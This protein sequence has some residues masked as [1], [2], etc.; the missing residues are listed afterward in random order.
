M[1]PQATGA[2]QSD[3]GLPDNTKRPVWREIV[4]PLLLITA[5]VIAAT[6]A[7]IFN[8]FQQKQQVEII[9]LKAIAE[10]R[11]RQ[12]VD[13]LK[14][15][16]RDTSLLQISPFLG[17]A[18]LQW[19][20]QG[21]IESRN[22]MLN[23]LATFRGDGSFQQAM[24]LD[25]EGEPL[26][27]SNLVDWEQKPLLDPLQRARY[28]AAAES[29]HVTRLGP[30]KDAAG[31]LHLDFVFRLQL[32]DRQPGP[33]VIMHSHDDDYLP[34]SMRDW[35]FPSASGEVLLFRREADHV[36]IISDVRFR[37]EASKTASAAMKLHVPLTAHAV[38]SVQALSDPAKLGQPLE[39]IDYRGEK[40]LGVV[41]AVPGTDWFLLAKRDRRE[42]LA[43]AYENAALTSLVGL[44]TLLVAGFALVSLHHRRRLAIAQGMQDAQGERLRALNL[45][46]S[47]ADSSTDVIY[48]KD[49]EGRYLLFNRE[50]ARVTGKPVDTVLGRDDA[51]LF[52]PE[53]VA[54]IQADDR[55]VIATGQIDSRDQELA[56]IG[57]TRIFQTT[58][59]PLRDG[60]GNVIGIFGSSRDIT[61]R[62]RLEV[63]LAATASF[64]AQAGG[65]SFFQDAVRHL[66]GHFD[67]DYVHVGRL[68][69]ETNQVET[70]AVWRDGQA[71]PNYRYSLAGTPCENVLQ[72]HSVC[73]EANVQAHYPL[74]KELQNLGAQG[75][76]GERMS[77]RDG[78][79]SGLFICISRAPLD[80]GT[81]I[82]SV[83]RI[84]AARAAAELEQQ[85]ALRTL[86]ERELF[87][88]AAVAGA[89]VGLYDWNCLT[90]QVMLAPEWKMQI[91]YADEE[92]PSAFASWQDHLH[93]DDLQRTMDYVMAFVAHPAPVFEIEYRMRHKDGFY[94]WIAARGT[95]TVDDS[96]RCTRLIGGHVDI[97]EHKETEGH[98]RKLA[99]AMEQS[100][101]SVIIVDLD[102]RIEYVN[103]AFLNTTGYT[104]EEVLGQNPRFLQSGKTPHETYDALWDALSHGKSWKG[105]FINRRKDASEYTEF[106][107]ITPLRQSHEAITHYVAVAEDIT[108]RKHLGQELDLHRHH[109]EI[110]VAERTSQLEFALDKAESASRTKAAFLANMSHEIRTPMNAILGMTYLLRRSE[111][112]SRQF[113]Q[114][115]RIEQASRLLL[116]LINDILDL[117]RVESGKLLLESI[118]VAVASIPANVASLLDEQVR[119]KGLQLQVD[120]GTLPTKLSG[121]PTR[122]TQ[123]LLN[124]ASNA[125]KFTRQGIVN[126]RCR[127]LAEDAASA[128]IRFEVED[129]GIGIAPDVVPRLFSA[130]EQA[131]ASTTRR[132][133]GSGLG[134][135][136]TRHLAELMGGEAGA[137]STP[138]VGSTFWFTVR[139]V[140]SN[141]TDSGLTAQAKLNRDAETI[142]ARDYRGT[143][144][145]LV[146]DDPINQEVA[147]GLLESV[148][149]LV[150]L[151][152]NGAVAVRRIASGG[153]FSVI[154]MDMQMP[155]MD[156]VEATRQIRRLENGSHVPILAMTANA[157]AEDRSICLE[158]GMNDFIAKPV[159]PDFLFATLLNWLPVR[160]PRTADA[161][162]PEHTGHDSSAAPSLPAQ[163]APL[164]SPELRKA[165]RLMGG[166][167]RYIQLLRDFATRHGSDIAQLETLLG[168]NR[169]EAARNLIHGLKGAAGS[170]GLIELKTAAAELEAVLRQKQ[171]AEETW[172]PLSIALNQV[173]TMLQTSVADL[174]AN[175]PPTMPSQQTAIDPVKA[176]SLLDRLE[177]LLATDDIAATDLF[178]E[179]HTLLQQWFDAG[180]ILL[181]Q[182][183][184]AF[185]YRA[186]LET[187]R[188]LRAQAPRDKQ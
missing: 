144:M 98:L 118:P 16:E 171:C 146:E 65:E 126:L 47:I 75:Y 115:D 167:E 114:I 11:N 84:L 155:V 72:K 57:G 162:I 2:A 135:A 136:I 80:K 148:G 123:S 117:S 182:Q 78:K 186:A 149:L 140:K 105:E 5:L 77:D 42:I 52:P 168:D 26:W 176:W 111:L 73:I 128:L 29:N 18:Y 1:N 87:L 180:A 122:L 173:L 35:P 161:H 7:I 107:V 17:T 125:V 34:A 103:A 85:E 127:L 10:L 166:T 97:T 120:T 163:L 147:T 92:L 178:G 129:S 59:G 6:H 36:L 62:R 101:E 100:I 142:L 4:W 145:L 95:P 41:H 54:M 49:L 3:S 69:P 33:I 93:P 174:V 165:M 91:G 15:R 38:L 40:V 121:D 19:R 102:A 106:A 48:A 71:L 119:A 21:N 37:P 137:T 172:A 56:T 175:L 82:P 184:S 83:L 32:P 63:A 188:M 46:A 61:A 187:L 20:T 27:D 22:R 9:Q 164:D 158:A 28:Y 64:V 134:L 179:N 185:D 109:L 50:A 74:D 88:R 66:A 25:P 55:R 153:Q 131:D 143:H 124:L 12:L 44:L 14:E 58:K 170:L 152:E 79:V 157:F 30:Y 130:F 13:W 108:D 86:S 160:P 94:R 89:R 183:I 169:Q 67:L 156:G 60:A 90:N 99:Q 70:L 53:Q 104:R 24:L 139:L 68:I 154:L 132:Y 112:S 150:E 76:M 23:R 159:D 31:R 51:L 151:A 39:G 45:L 81:M 177:R 8:S 181:E 141:A 113:E 110:L 96:G 133:G 138:G 43:E 116:G